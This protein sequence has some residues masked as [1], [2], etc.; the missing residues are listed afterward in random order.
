MY[1][2]TDYIHKFSAEELSKANREVKLNVMRTWF[3][4]RYEDPQNECPYDSEDGYVYIWGGPYD[5]GEELQGEFSDFIPEDVIDALAKELE[6]EK[7]VCD[8]SA[9]RMEDHVDNYFVD[10]ITSTENPHDHLR[11]TLNTLSQL[12]N[13]NTDNQLDQKMLEMIY[14]N[15]ITT[16]EAYLSEFFVH[17]VLNNDEKLRIFIETNPDFKNIKYTLAEISSKAEFIKETVREY[18]GDLIWHNLGRV[19][20]MFN[21]ALDIKFPQSIDYLISSIRVRHDLVHRGGKKKNGARITIDRTEVERLIDE[22]KSFAAHIEEG[23]DSK[24][25]F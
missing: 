3:F 12:S 16:L 20:P 4:E 10:A 9:I 6:K 11:A 8:W 22:V 18:L 14:V 13:I 5:A 7:G 17:E 25:P 1:K 15:I 21:S 19:K 23:A 24:C 2:H